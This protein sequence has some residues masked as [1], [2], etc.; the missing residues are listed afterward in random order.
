[1]Q[2]GEE[3]LGDPEDGS[4]SDDLT[5]SGTSSEEEPRR[6]R[7]SSTRTRSRRAA[8]SS[9]ESESDSESE[10]EEEQVSR[11]SSRRRSSKANGSAGVHT[12]GG[13]KSSAERDLSK[14]VKWEK[15]IVAFRLAASPQEL[16][17]GVKSAEVAICGAAGTSEALFD[18]E[19]HMIRAIKVIHAQNTFPVSM[20]LNVGGMKSDIVDVAAQSVAAPNGTK[21]MLTLM[22]NETVSA[23][24]Q[25]LEAPSHTTDNEFLDL[26]PGMTVETL[27][28]CVVTM[29]GEDY[30]AVRVNHPALN[31]FNIMRKR[32]DPNARPLGQKDCGLPGYIGI[33][34]DVVDELLGELETTMSRDLKILDINTMTVTFSRAFGTP[35]D[36]GS[37]AWDD[38]EELTAE[39]SDGFAIRRKTD[40]KHVSVKMEIEYRKL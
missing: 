34:R 32:R 21:G 28:D 40:V 15:R 6:K 23:P 13:N 10:S 4:T 9:S 17:D 1:M 22:E 25:I 14:P 19:T 26:Y 31:L 38:A 3:F 16:A 30:Y 7:R 12:V 5:S 18:G 36:K 33:D 35:D 20:H 2:C 37:I 27:R 29:P 11:R 39:A 8:P 24:T